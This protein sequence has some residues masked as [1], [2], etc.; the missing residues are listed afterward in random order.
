MIDLHIHTNFSDGELSP[1]EI[2]DEAVKNGVT[3]IAI[4]DHDTI[5]AYSEELYQY[6]KLKNV[7]LLNAVEISTKYENFFVHILGYNF[8]INNKALKEKL[9]LVRN[10]RHDYLYNV[11][12]KLMELGYSVNVEKLDKIEAVTKAHIASDIV[13]N[14][15]NTE[16]LL[17]EFGHIP[18]RGEF[19]EKIM[20]SRCPAYVRKESLTPKEAVEL[21]KNAGGKA[22]LAHP[23]A[24]TH[25]RDIGK[26]EILNLAKEIGIDGIETYYI[27]VDA[28][29]KEKIDEIEEW[30]KLAK[31]NDFFVTVG[32]DFH[33]KCGLHPQI[34]LID[35]KINLSENEM[36]DIISNL[37]KRIKNREYN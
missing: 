7:K 29:T 8:D 31:E 22:V 32:S 9:T 5:E 2:I 6:A 3:T 33:S 13:N 14:H 26:N 1:K 34:G 35:E 16:I 17:E 19:I 30:T 37:E 23:V 24:Y 21:I 36:I 20:N 12:K 18:N 28:N 27:L 11:S 4:A 15:E 25:I 10:A